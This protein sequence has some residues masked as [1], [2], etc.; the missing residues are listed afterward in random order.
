MARCAK[1]SIPNS[2]KKLRLN[3]LEIKNLLIK[4]Q[5]N[6]IALFLMKNANRGAYMK[7]DD[8]GKDNCPE[9]EIDGVKY[10]ICDICLDLRLLR[11]EDKSND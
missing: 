4:K 1:S 11:L 9:R 7:C 2:A 8:C 6:G 3:K 10:V 5:K